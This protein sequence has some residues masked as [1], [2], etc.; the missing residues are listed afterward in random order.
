L[1]LSFFERMAS[2]NSLADDVMMELSPAAFADPAM[3]FCPTAAAAPAS[4]T[5]P[6]KSRRAILSLI[7]KSNLA[8]ARRRQKISF[9]GGAQAYVRS[10]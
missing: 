9:S 3:K 5:V 8:V 1:E 4:A 7:E 10:G 2:A 6:R